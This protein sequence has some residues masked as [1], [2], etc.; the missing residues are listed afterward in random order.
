MR[1][2]DRLLLYIQAKG[3]SHYKVEKAIGVSSGYLTKQGKKKG[4]LGVEILDKIR[5]NYPDL[6]LLWVITGEGSMWGRIAENPGENN[7]LEGS[8]GGDIDVGKPSPKSSPLPSPL[9]KTELVEAIQEALPGTDKLKD[10]IIES[11]RKS[12]EALQASNADK[13]A[14]IALL[15]EKLNDK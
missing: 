15:N 11:Q 8:F 10:E 9:S 2:I 6:N 12:I 7:N 13:Q 3:L 14:I 5:V 4:G 1:A